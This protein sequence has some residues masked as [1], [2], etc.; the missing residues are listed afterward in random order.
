MRTIKKWNELKARYLHKFPLRVQ[1]DLQLFKTTNEEPIENSVFIFGEVNTG[2]T[3]LASQMMFDELRFIYL[4]A[5]PDVHNKTMFVSFP[6]MLVEIKRSFGSI[7]HNTE[8]ILDKYLNAHFLVLDDF[9]SSRPTDWVLE[10]IYHLINYRYERMLK[11]VITS[12]FGLKE[13]ESI[14]G[15]QRITS[16]ISRSYTIIEKQPY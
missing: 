15:E 7:E 12:N 14:L 16:R 3:I 6:D 10:T 2:K 5:I 1:R 13:L 8:N 9:L 11:T 4:H